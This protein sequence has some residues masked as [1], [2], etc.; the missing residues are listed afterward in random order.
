MTFSVLRIRMWLPFD[1]YF[2]GPKLRSLG[3]FQNTV[4]TDRVE[5]MPLKTQ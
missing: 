5:A 3:K 1:V 4:S 2:T